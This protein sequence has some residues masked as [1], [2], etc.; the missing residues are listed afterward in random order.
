MTCLGC[1][2]CEEGPV[3][4]LHDGRVVCSYCE[5]WRAECE[6]RAV[7][8]MSGKAERN[9]FLADVERIRGKEAAEELKRLVWTIW[10]KPND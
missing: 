5:D 2:R 4:T 6:A 3:V 9:R 10:K 1:Q 7:I 8:A